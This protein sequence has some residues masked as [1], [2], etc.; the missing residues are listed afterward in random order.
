MS[1]LVLPLAIFI[2]VDAVVSGV[3]AGDIIGVV[4]DANTGVPFV[5]EAGVTVA[6]GAALGAVALI[7]GGDGGADESCD[8]DVELAF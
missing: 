3:I 1:L 8:V 2:D 4:I 5:K 6:V 7:G